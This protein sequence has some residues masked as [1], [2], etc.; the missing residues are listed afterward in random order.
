MCGVKAS[1]IHSTVNK[2]YAGEYALNTAYRLKN[3]LCFEWN[4]GQILSQMKLVELCGNDNFSIYP[5][6][7]CNCVKF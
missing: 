3:F 6:V 5:Y 4:K 2:V 1:F 7:C